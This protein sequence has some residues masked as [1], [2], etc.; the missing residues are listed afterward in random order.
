M[1][2]NLYGPGDNYDLTNLHVLPAPIRK[3]HEAK[4][5]KGQEV[6]VWGTGSPRRE[7]LYS[8]NL[9][10]ACVFLMERYNSGDIGES[11]NIGI[12]KDV[13]IRKAAEVITEIVVFDVRLIFDTN[14]PDGIPRKLL[15]VSRLQTLGW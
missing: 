2:S 11:I 13:T 15:D 12:G 7:F 9:A 1:P 14:K 10:D 6:V 4:I 5:L 3:V 8:Y